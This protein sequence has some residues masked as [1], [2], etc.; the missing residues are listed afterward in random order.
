MQWATEFFSETDSIATNVLVLSIVI[1]SGLMLGLI[2]VGGVRLGV[3]GVLFS[4]LLFGHFGL[5][6]DPTVL[7]FTREFGLVLFVFA[8]GLT[9]GPGFF[10][11]LRA[12]GLSLNILATAVVLIGVLLTFAINRI[13]GIEMPIAVG[14]FSGATTNTPSLA[15]AVQTIRDHPPRESRAVRAMMQAGSDI[16]LDEKVPVGEVAKLPGL[17]YAISYPFGVVGII[18]SM[19]VMRSVFRVNP[20]LEGQRLEKSLK[21]RRPKVERLNLRVTNRNLD[22][23]SLQNVPG[24]DGSSVVVSRVMHDGVLRVPFSDSPIHVDDVLLAV[25]TPDQLER[26]RIVVGEP[27]TIDLM[28]VPGEITYRWAVIS[29]KDLVGQSLDDLH[30]ASRFGVQVT[31]IRRAEVE[32]PPIAKLRLGLGDEILIVG[33]ADAVT[34]ASNKL[35]NMPKELVRSDLAPVF[36]GIGLGVVIGGIP[37]SFPGATSAV[38]L[39]LAGGPLLVAILLGS[40][41]RVGPW[42][43][44]LPTAAS[45][46]LRD[47]C[48]AM[49]LATV[50]IRGGD[51]FVSSLLQGDGLWW[52]LAGAIV[53]VVPLL[54][55][56]AIG[57]W[58]LRINYPTLVGVIAV[59]MTDPP[60]LAFANAQTESELPTI[61]YAT[62]IP[63]TMIL[64]VLAAQGLVLAGV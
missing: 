50:G 42:I 10:N 40:L 8:I 35:G 15:A 25:G 61:G 32:M 55:V 56:G 48:I 27:A 52:L 47:I 4:G 43:F 36:I 9:I 7:D 28:E 24:M 53:T 60:A 57:H 17:A 22:G 58:F 1:S 49:F 19:L 13:A 6:L 31:R 64:R 30:L 3:A 51:K 11:A 41:G 45:H 33:R 16:D 26:L 14:I 20:A 34:A 38:K 12:Q 39:G 5:T 46:I 21:S 23:M 59:S 62:V 2:P 18:L 63:L 37:I 54:V 44:Y 29:R